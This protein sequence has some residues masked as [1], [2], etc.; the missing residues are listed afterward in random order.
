MKKILI[1][2]L[3]IAVSFVYANGADAIKVKSSDYEIVEDAAITV[4][5]LEDAVDNAQVVKETDTIRIVKLNDKLGI[6]DKRTHTFIFKPV[7]DTI[8]TFPNSDAEYK[9][10][11]KDFVGYLNTNTGANF[12][13]NYDD[14]FLMDKYI[15]VKK[16][17][18]YGLLDKDG[19]MILQPAYQ[20]VSVINSG[21][22]EY[23]SAKY[24]GK[25]KMFYNTGRLVP[26]KDLYT[27]SNDSSYTLATD[28]KPI[29]KNTGNG[30][31]TLYERAQYNDDGYYIEIKELKLPGKVKVASELPDVKK[32][33]VNNTTN[34]LTINNKEFKIVNNNGRIGIDDLKGNEIVPAVYSSFDLKRPC[35]HFSTDVIVAKKGPY[36][37][38]Y[39]L[40]GNLIAEQLPDKVNV[41]KSGKVYSYT[42]EGGK[43]IL[44]NNKK[45][46][47]NVVVT[48]TGYKF[49]K[50]AFTFVNLH[51]AN[52]LLLTILS[53]K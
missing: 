9:V 23:I 26:E 31:L 12:L 50:T 53:A 35:E 49:T 38:I 20:Q 8:D 19:N 32:L 7:L 42:Y 29:F 4:P 43:W 34:S 45:E 46:L 16:S 21:D 48:N 24:D 28:I 6:Y 27:I 44:R 1:L 30:T 33:N 41:Y 10:R 15:K 17:G 18:K 47:G 25:Y 5:K 13:T 37:T 36:H 51:K 22:T 39:D 40:K 14:I 2:T 52:E 11:A 3:L